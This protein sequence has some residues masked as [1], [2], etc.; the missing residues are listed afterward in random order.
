MKKFSRRSI[1]N[2]I[3][4][5]I[6]SVPALSVVIFVVWSL[7]FI[8]KTALKQA[9]EKV[10]LDLNSGRVIYNEEL[11]SLC[12]LVLYQAMRP[13]IVSGI[14]GRKR[15]DL[16]V[17]LDEMVHLESTDILVATD[18]KGVVVARAGKLDFC[19]DDL[20]T[21]KLISKALKGARVAATDLLS[22]E[23]LAHEGSELAERARIKIVP[24]PRAKLAK[25]PEY[26]DGGMVL[27]A[28]QPVTDRGKVVGALYAAK[29][30]NRNFAIV[31]KTRDTVYRDR[32]YKGRMVG[33]ATIFQGE[34]RISTNV[35]RSNGT[36]AIGTC[37]SAEVGE[38]CLDKGQR[39]IGRAFVVNDWYITAYEPIYDIDKN[40]IGVLY[41]GTLESPYVGLKQDLF[42][43][44]ALFIIGITPFGVLI[45]IFVSKKIVRPIKELAGASEKIAEGDY[46]K[47]AIIESEDEIGMLAS[48][49]NRMAESVQTKTDALNEAQRSLYD[50]SK[51]LERLVEERTQR[52]LA[53]EMRYANLFE[54]ANDAFFT[55]DKD[56]IFTSIND[57]GASLAGYPKEEI[58]GRMTLLGIVHGD[59]QARI[60]SMI[61]RVFAGRTSTVGISFRIIDKTG[62]EKIV[63]MNI[64]VLKGSATDTEI[65]GIARDVTERRRLEEEV[66]R[67]RDELQVLF[68]SITDGINVV[69]RNYSIIKANAGMAKQ[70]GIPVGNMIGRKCYK[71]FHDR[72]GRC[73]RCLVEET[74]RTG[75][76]AFE[77]RERTRTDGTTITVDVFT[78]PIFNN[79]NQ[80]IQAVEYSRDVTEGKQLEKHL[81][82]VTKMESIGVLAGGI[83][84]DFNNLLSG[85]LG[86]ASL[87][88][89]KLDEGN[90]LFKYAD[91]IEQSALKAA[92]LTQQ[93]LTFSRGGESHRETTNV[94]RIAEETSQLLE[95]TLDKNIII[96][97][98]LN[99]DTWPIEADPSQ[100]EQV[101]L[102]I[103]INARDAMPSGGILAIKTENVLIP[104]DH[105]A[106]CLLA[107]VDGKYVKI[108][109]SDTGLGI[110]KGIQDK[111]FDPFFTTKDKTKG[112]GLG[113][114]VVYGVVK[115]HEGCIHVESEVLKG[116]TFDIYL[117][118]SEKELTDNSIDAAPNEFV[119]GDETILLIDDEQIIRE[120]GK[121]IL[122]NSGYKVMLAS[123]GI[124][125][126]TLY[127][128]LK[129][130]IALVILDMI[131]PRL[132][133]I[134]TFDRLRLMNPAVKV[135]VSSGYSADGHYQAV[136][137]NG[138]RGFIQKPYKIRDLTKI[139]RQVLDQE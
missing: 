36:R 48:S 62:K 40:T 34:T 13:S 69:D 68:N 75:D 96:R 91:T 56:C 43:Q 98:K 138:A 117:P 30:L 130:E 70:R 22:L 77:T 7:D 127:E 83:A 137:R 54:I 27:A 46:T 11:Q 99:S 132:G 78:F 116:T 57:Y 129:K 122:E 35:K 120:L 100:I 16:K 109:I 29:L 92:R 107:A 1:R 115:N 112:T 71:V 28:A 108:S 123:D 139:V 64:S 102:N 44:I 4:L 60:R 87:F 118:A 72:D 110:D 45:S 126:L 3:L 8:D 51:N 39:W 86:Y 26:L 81:F 124:E 5:G 80:V 58:L 49:F 14:T 42:G 23:R 85:I 25:R 2:R 103:C 33:T 12:D 74:F 32:L 20:S 50:Y 136:L 37:I 95:R 84:H 9:Q 119:R 65:L 133:G 113:L 61:D 89:V 55:I 15:A 41:V 114:S 6:L 134:E 93:L 106:A 10:E 135:I 66:A 38:A 105:Q 111:I 82:Q 63:E 104:C 53:T 19:D 73:K 21:D 121:E 128:N 47:R 125:A 90:P 31:D 101:L 131:M 97:K 67:T 79:D 94:N 88:K 24:T 52:L 76:P 59:D 17:Q 18:S